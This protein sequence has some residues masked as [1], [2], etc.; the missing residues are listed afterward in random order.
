MK[1]LFIVL[2]I[3]FVLLIGA[4]SVAPF[5]I[6]TSV[7]K[8]QIENTASTALNRSVTLNGDVKLSLF[9]TIKASVENVAVANPEGFSDPHMVE[10]GALSG[11]LKWIP[12]FS[13]RVEVAELGFVDATVRLERLA[14][15]SV[16]WD[17]AGVDET[18][19]APEDTSDQ[20]PAE[21]QTVNAGIDKAR[22]VNANVFYSDAMTGARY[23]LTEF[24]A[25]ASMQSFDQPLS[26]KGNGN[27]QDQA[28]RFEIDLASPEAALNGALT[29]ATFEF[30]S[31]L[32][33]LAF[34]GDLALGDAMTSDGTFSANVPDIPAIASFADTPLPAGVTALQAFTSKGSIRGGLT[35]PT[36]QFETL[37][38]DSPLIQASY[39][40]LVD[41]SSEGRVDGQISASSDD[42]RSLLSAAEVDLA[43]GETLKSF[44][45]SAAPK[46]S[47][48]AIDLGNLDFRLDD[49]VATGTAGLNLTGARPKVTADLDL[50]TLNLTPFMSEGE[51]QAPAETSGGSGWSTEPLDLAGLKAADADLQLSIGTLI[52]DKITLTDAELRAQLEAGNLTTNIAQLTA[53]GGSW[54]GAFG[55]D[56]GPATPRLSMNL[57]GQNIAITDMLTSFANLDSVSGS[58]A[59]KLNVTS[60]GSSLDA[61]VKGLN[62]GVSTNLADGAVKGFNAGQLVRS[63]SDVRGALAAGNFNLALSE[64]E[65]TDFTNFNSI[66][67]IRNGV[68]NV[69]ALNLI[70]PIVGLDGSGEINLGAQTLDLSILTSIDESATGQTSNVQ[71]N[72]IPIPFRLSGSW[73]SPSISPDTRLLQQALTSQL[74][75]RARDE[76][77]GFLDEALGRGNSEESESDTS[78]SDPQNLEDALEDAATDALSDLFGRNRN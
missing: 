71:L 65:E 7:Y 60:A 72:G 41:L 59:V 74:E 13:G 31:D 43:P 48:D 15:G 6:P 21:G 14:D 40:G 20:P 67:S 68:A 18:D 66:L 22:L 44:A 25:E 3:V 46:G 39:R 69:D 36:I 37:S 28:F 5:L 19:P 55:L 35:T 61:L 23:E 9:P 33:D 47:F 49:L 1:R 24:S 76:L 26:A 2:G 42:L 10:A 8:N 4:I 64:E 73:T 77:T 54:Q 50:P 30:T 51:S 17:F 56:A 62:G 45:L 29:A 11:T 32:A 12:L 63:V 27:F 16:N 78:D 34:N 52:I 38:I 58:G 75:D 57:T 70:G 53:F